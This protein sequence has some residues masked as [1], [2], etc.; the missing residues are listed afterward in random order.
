M[1][2]SRKIAQRISQEELIP[3]ISKRNKPGK[4]EELFVLG[5]VGQAFFKA[6]VSITN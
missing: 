1:L 3:I 4:R 5:E 2:G 6:S